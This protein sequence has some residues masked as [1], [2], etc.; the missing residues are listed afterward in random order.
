MKVKARTIKVGA[1]EELEGNCSLMFNDVLG[2]FACEWVNEDLNW[3]GELGKGSAATS[4][5]VF[6]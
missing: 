3:R 1:E 5:R 2:D 6:C 4:T